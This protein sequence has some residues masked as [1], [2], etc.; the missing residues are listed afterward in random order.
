MYRGTQL[1]RMQVPGK[2]CPCLVHCTKLTGNVTHL[3]VVHGER[4]AEHILGVANEAA[5]GGSGVQVPQTEGT[6]P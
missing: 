6:V 1:A 3:T 2:P 4:N 5:G